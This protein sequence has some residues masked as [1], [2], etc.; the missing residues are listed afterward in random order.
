VTRLSTGHSTGVA[1]KLVQEGEQTT[2]IGKSGHCLCD[3][4]AAGPWELF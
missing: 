1:I 4:I 2:E 3:G